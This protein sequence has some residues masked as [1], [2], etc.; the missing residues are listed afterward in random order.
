[1]L[2]KYCF[3]YVLKC[4]L[5]GAGKASALLL[6][7]VLDILTSSK[8]YH[9]IKIKNGLEARSTYNFTSSSCANPLFNYLTA[10]S[11]QI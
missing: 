11:L 10:I 8:G 6:G 2:R 1:M 7:A 4:E 9:H 3:F 5:S